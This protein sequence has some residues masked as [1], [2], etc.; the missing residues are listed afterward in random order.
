MIGDIINNIDSSYDPVKAP[1]CDHLLESI[2]ITKMTD[3]NLPK[4]LER[5]EAIAT[6]LAS[7][8]AKENTALDK[9]KASV[10]MN[11]L[12]LLDRILTR[13]KNHEL[14]SIYD[15]VRQKITE[16]TLAGVVIQLL[17][18]DL[19][20]T[21]DNLIVM[22]E[23]NAYKVFSRRTVDGMSFTDTGVI[24]HK[25]TISTDKSYYDV[26]GAFVLADTLTFRKL[27]GHAVSKEV[28]PL[29]IKRTG[30]AYNPALDRPDT[31][32]RYN[33]EISLPIL[34]LDKETI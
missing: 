27:I 30:K 18:L 31:Y 25:G 15:F 19:L 20:Y 1:Y 8:L 34:V 10:F 6:Q 24:T 32:F 26:S 11:A 12:N 2:G 5:I 21:D 33:N 29:V 9:K 3:A 7:C 13:L 22:Q 23:I 16:T 4:A 17:K 14:S 28:F